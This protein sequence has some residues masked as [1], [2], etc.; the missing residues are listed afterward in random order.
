[1]PESYAI[2]R[3]LLARNLVIDYREGAGIRIAPHFYNTD[4][5]ARAAITAIGEIIADGS[6]QPYSQNR[7]FV[8]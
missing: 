3:A 7:A 8:T 1:M 2:S 6:W 5:E 4:D